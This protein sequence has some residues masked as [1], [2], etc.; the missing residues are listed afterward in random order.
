MICTLE[1]GGVDERRVLS[2]LSGVGPHPRLGCPAGA[3]W[4]T[5]VDHPTGRTRSRAVQVGSTS[6]TLDIDIVTGIPRSR[7]RTREARTDA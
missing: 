7:P 1:I 3:L 4:L 2:Q 6:T 5:V